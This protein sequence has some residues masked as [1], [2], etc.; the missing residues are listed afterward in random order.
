MIE[1]RKYLFHLLLIVALIAVS[2]GKDAPASTPRDPQDP[3]NPPTDTSNSN[4]SSPSASILTGPAN[5]SS[6]LNGVITDD[7]STTVTFQWQ[8][9]ANADGY[10]LV[11][12]GITN[13][14][15]YTKTVTGLTTELTLRT[16]QSY[17]WYVVSTSTKTTKTATSATWQFYLAGDPVSS[18][19]PFPAIA[20]SPLDNEVVNAN[21][22]TSLV[23]TIKWKAEDIDNDIASYDVYFDQADATTKVTSAQTMAALSRIVNPGKTY[24]WR[25]VTTDKMGNS[26]DSGQFI[27]TVQ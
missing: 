1:K 23:L 22:A 27:F 8:A 14:K 9:A 12:T 24:Y 18:Y 26:S 13:G 3:Q 6:C 17:K 20:V 5:N 10:K 4:S 11:V 21:G 7:T 16:N 25:V 2:C 19:A 15:Q